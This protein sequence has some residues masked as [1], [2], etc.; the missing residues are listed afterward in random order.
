MLRFP[1]HSEPLQPVDQAQAVSYAYIYPLAN[2]K[3]CRWILPSI[4]GGSTSASDSSR[5][6][7]SP[8]ISSFETAVDDGYGVVNLNKQRV[9]SGGVL[10][11]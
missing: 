5:S 2:D 7:R 8:Q 10:G 3:S 1:P 9:F 6:I 11:G 4:C